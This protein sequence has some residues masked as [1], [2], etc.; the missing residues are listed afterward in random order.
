MCVQSFH[1]CGHCL[2]D[3]LDLAAEGGTR[4]ET[5][6]TAGKMAIVWDKIKKH[7]Q[8]NGDLYY[9]FLKVLGVG[10]TLVGS[11]IGVFMTVRKCRK[12]GEEEGECHHTNLKLLMPY[13]RFSV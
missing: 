2:P 6:V 12:G 5:C 1:D 7:F 4:L 9:T 11:V 10:V 8:D 13:F 3:H